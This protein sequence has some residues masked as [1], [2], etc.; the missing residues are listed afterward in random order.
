M[1][2]TWLV[3]AA[4]VLGGFFAYLELDGDEGGDPLSREASADPK[5]APAEPEARPVGVRSDAEAESQAARLVRAADQARAAGDAAALAKHES[6]LR[7]DYWESATA[8]SYAV[9]QGLALLRGVEK[10]QPR[11]ARIE[12]MDK[13]RRLLSRGVWLPELFAKNGEPTLARTNLISRIKKL[14]RLVYNFKEGN[15]ALDGV[16]RMYTVK[17]GEAPVQIVSRQRLPYGSN[18]L[19]YWNM[20]ER[21]NA[22]LLRANQRI[23]LPVEELHL[24]VQRD[25]YRLAIFLGDVFVKEFVVGVG[26]P[27]SPTPTGEFR[28][29]QRQLHPDWWGPDGLV[30][31][32]E[33]G[34]ELGDLWISIES[35][36]YPVTASYG[37]HGTTRPETVGSRCSQ[38]CVR[39]R[40]KEAIE[41]YDWVRTGSAKGKATRVIIR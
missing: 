5:G 15:Q 41:L 32:G 6:A 14:N 21:L 11:R 2:A 40:N 10:V 38:G 31:W 30:K 20:G 35:D 19:L 3:L 28:V 23:L 9:K 29:H 25:V 24:E 13:A 16:T 26:K 27:D 36:E 4:V 8:R 34:H 17:S 33:E 18:A 7:K 1:R 22:K 12:R 39:L 37:I